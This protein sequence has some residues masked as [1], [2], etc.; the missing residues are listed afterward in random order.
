M[1]KE[2][3]AKATRGEEADGE[4]WGC[5]STPQGT[6]VPPA[7]P[8]RNQVVPHGPASPVAFSDMETQLTASPSLPAWA[9]KRYRASVE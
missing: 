8:A 2:S 6:Q 7:E 3:S 4:E 9:K 5:N 1:E